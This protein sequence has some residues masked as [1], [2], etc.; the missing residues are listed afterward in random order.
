MPDEP[1]WAKL[2][3]DLIKN[4]LADRRFNPVDDP[5]LRVMQDIYNEMRKRVLET[6][7]RMNNARAFNV[8]YVDPTLPAPSRDGLFRLGD[9]EFGYGPDICPRCGQDRNRV[10]HCDPDKHPDKAKRMLFDPDSVV[11][12]SVIDDNRELE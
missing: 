11:D 6:Q 3:N 7:R 8:R 12:G 9:V 10:M 2:R 4:T 1:E 5:R